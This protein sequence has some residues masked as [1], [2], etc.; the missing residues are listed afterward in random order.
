MSNI[1]KYIKTKTAYLVFAVLYVLFIGVLIK[2]TGVITNNEAEKYITAAQSI[3]EGKIRDVYTSHLF[4]TS[5]ILF[6][7]I[8][9]VSKNAILVVVAQSILSYLSAVY[10]KRITDFI[11]G[12]S[13]YSYISMGVFLFS[14]PIQSWTITLFSESFFISLSIITLFFTLKQ[15]TKSEFTLWIC[16]NLVLIFARPPGIFLVLPNIAYFAIQSKTTSAIVAAVAYSIAL[17]TTVLFL[18][19]MPAETKGYI[20]PIAAERIIVDSTDYTVPE[21]TTAPKSTIAEAYTYIANKKGT[22]QLIRLYAKKTISFFT[23]QRSYY[24]QKHNLLLL[25]F[26][27]LYMLCLI[28]IYYLWKSKKKEIAFLFSASIFGLTNLVALTYNEWHYRFTITIFPFLIILSTL[29][30]SFLLTSKSQFKKNI[31]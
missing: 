16:L 25:P 21:F 8:F 29:S 30:V 7:S 2:T 10:L 22:F 20:R 15:K 28:G 1:I 9:Y 6:L 17:L 26:Y 24:S 27:V 31:K 13:K 5:Y 14:F 11:I 12:K 4:Y 18:F 23:L 3:Y 19:Y